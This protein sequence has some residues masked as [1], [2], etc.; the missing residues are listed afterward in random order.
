MDMFK[1]KRTR[2]LFALFV[3]SVILT[4]GC[5]PSAEQILK[6]S[7]R[8][9]RAIKTAH[10]TIEMKTTLPRAPIR[11]GKIEKRVFV[12]NSEGDYD[13][14]T[15]DFKIATKVGNL[16]LV[17]MLQVEGKQYWLVAGNWYEP[18][19]TIE[20]TPPITTSLSVSQYVKYFKVL[21]KLRGLSI[22]GDDCHHV[23]G[24]PNMKEL[25]K[26][27]GIVDLMKDPTGKQ[28]RTIDEL[29]T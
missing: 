16:D 15:N 13:F 7:A 8:S 20:F 5:G 14:R 23:M 29:E 3:V 6:D 17:T 19:Q 11:E 12:Q 2:G 24:V 10:F 26:Q 9:S 4:A 22:D 27:P 28:V 1:G 25:V 21:K 18:P